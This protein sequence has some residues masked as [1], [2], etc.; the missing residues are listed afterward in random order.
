[1]RRIDAT[2]IRAHTRTNMPAGFDATFTNVK[3]LVADFL[4]IKK[5]GGV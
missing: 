3:E 5:N 4:A 1:M 2:V